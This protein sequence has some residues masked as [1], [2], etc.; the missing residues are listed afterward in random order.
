MQVAETVG[1]DCLL[2]RRSSVSLVLGKAV[3]R[4]IRR[5]PD[6][7]AVPYYFGGNRSE[8]DRWYGAVPAN[9]CF[10]FVFLR[11]MEKSIQIYMDVGRRGGK[12]SNTRM[13]GT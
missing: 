8:H 10:L 6:H 2:V 5:Q 7:K 11:R 13:H 1:T 12:I 9:N 3:L 4:I